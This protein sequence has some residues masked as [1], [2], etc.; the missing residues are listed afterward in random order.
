MFGGCYR[1]KRVLVTGHT[2]FK[3][4]WL[5]LWLTSLG[6]QVTG[7]A[8]APPT[9]PNHWD[10]LDLDIEDLRIDIR[11][12][13]A[14]ADA[15]RR[16]RPEMVF[17]L[18]AQALV[19]ASYA[20][21]LGTWGSNVMG[22]AHVLEACRQAGTTEA[23]LVVTSDKCYDNREQ[24]IA[25]RETD[26]L[27]GHDP[28]SASKASAEL[29]TAS[30]RDAFF[31]NERGP[32][33]ATARAGNVIGGGDWA[34]DR[35]VPDLVRAMASGAQL[36][37]RSPHSVRPWQH[38]LEPLSGYLLLG[39]HLLE[40]RPGAASPWNFGP[41]A[42]QACS[43]EKVLA[44]LQTH[45]PQLAC[46]VSSMPHPHEARTLQLD[47]TK[48]RDE[49]G[50]LPV[51]SLDD[52][53]GATAAWYRAHQAGQVLSATQLQTYVDAALHAGSPWARA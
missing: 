30:Y 33:V 16:V 44:K 21:P 47:S 25:F 14:V 53:L 51:W 35:L 52:A 34:Q 32:R 42:S 39:Q 4:S 49:L 3:G 9:A 29:L 7:L 31:R 41:P 20:D 18:A 15:V 6:A 45:W 27:G 38:V 28:Y 12:A 1:G 2:G 40:A 26:L 19:R 37:V 46:T 23:V 17:H 10:L 22:T 24:S 5:A 13:S 11:D 48:A 50:W 8:L 36:D 43:V